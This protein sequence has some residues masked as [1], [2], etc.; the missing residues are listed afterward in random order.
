MKKIIPLLFLFAFS[1][2]ACG[3]NTENKV[4]IDAKAEEEDV[5]TMWYYQEEKSVYERPTAPVEPEGSYGRLMDYYEM[6]S[7]D[8]YFLYQE[9]LTP[10]QEK[11]YYRVRAPRTDAEYAGHVIWYNSAEHSFEEINL[12]TDSDVLLVDI[13]VS[14]EGTILLFDWKR[15]Y[16]YLPGEEQCKA[17]FP[18]DPR[19]GTVF[20]DDTHLICQPVMDSAYMVFDLRTG[21]KTEDYISREFLHEGTT[22]GGSFLARDQETELLATGNGIYEKEGEEW[23]LKVSSERTSMTLESFRPD[24]IWKEGD[25]YFLVAENMLYHYCIAEI[26]TEEEEIELKIFSASESAFLKE[27]ILQYQMLHPNINIDYKFAAHNEPESSQEMDTLLKQVNA[28]IISDQAA[29][30]YVL[31]MLPWEEY[32]QKGVMMNIDGAV[33][34]FL[35]TGEYFDGVLGG[36][37]EEKGIFVVPLFFKA[38]CFVCK[39]EMKPYVESLE[40][41][42]GYLKAYPEESGLGPYSYHNNVKGFFLPMLYQFYGSEL[43]EDEKVTKES[44]AAFL[45]NAKVIYDR[46][47][48]D[49]DK[50][51][52][53]T[54]YPLKYNTFENYV[55]DEMWQLLGCDRGSMSLYVI[56]EGNVIAVPQIFHYE[57]YEIFSNGQFHPVM[58]MG[59]HSQ[60]KQPEEAC[61]FLQFLISYTKSYSEKV[62]W[63]RNGIGVPISRYTPGVWMERWRERGIEEFGQEFY[64]DRNYGESYPV[65]LPVEGDSERITELLDQAT[66]PR[67]YASSLTDSVYAILAQGIDGYF[68]GEKS[69]ET[70]VD[71]LY[72][73]ISIKQSEEE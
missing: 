21:E 6:E 47:E 22:N 58:L 44:L 41:L 4:Q 3:K 45:E 53:N 24:G 62:Y 71:E 56:G 29:D 5:R 20:W 52:D 69:L 57:E 27:A 61:D 32:V 25:E 54:Y 36:Y 30:I 55:L 48:R 46:M 73:K 9:D 14:E 68:E 70:T 43:Y 28:E 26:D 18:S 34:P 11:S 50:G 39:K 63:C 64:Y 10:E 60:T 7:G 12:E 1:L 8:I 2:T 17:D 65:Y 23:I 33:N 67:G 59:V 72:S 16:V 51:G 66:V 15:A 38:D 31:D 40:T 13:R 49:N 19:G 42:A 37:Q 35:G